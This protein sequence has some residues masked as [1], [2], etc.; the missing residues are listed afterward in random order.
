[1]A[2]PTYSITTDDP[3]KA[4]QMM[5]IAAG[6]ASAQSTV[7]PGPA[8]SPAPIA[9][10]APTP[11]PAPVS[12]PI[13]MPMAN[14]APLLPGAPPAAAPAPAPPAPPPAAAPAPVAQGGNASLAAAVTA[15]V[16]SPGKSAKDAAAFIV[17]ATSARPD[18]DPKKGSSKYQDVP[19][20]YVEWLK[21][22]LAV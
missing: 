16:K 8:P 14:S 12:A 6:V 7:E 9:T 22:Q 15:Y 11:T 2:K 18:G 4:Q 19:E 13:A 21:Q 3:V 17:Q 5:A 10:P 20:E 1:M